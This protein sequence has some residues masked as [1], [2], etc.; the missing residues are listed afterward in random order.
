MAWYV[1]IA[2]PDPT[3]GAASILEGPF[4]T[5]LPSFAKDGIE[6]EK[7]TDAQECHI[8]IGM[9][10]LL[11]DGSDRLEATIV[12]DGYVDRKRCIT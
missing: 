10:D 12:H 11:S 3:S 9:L 4:C 2:P 5:Q 8:K 7:G 1:P 6:N